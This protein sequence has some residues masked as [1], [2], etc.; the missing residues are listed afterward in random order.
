[1]N[2]RCDKSLQNNSKEFLKKKGYANSL[3]AYKLRKNCAN[4]KEIFSLQ[5]IKFYTWNKSI[6]NVSF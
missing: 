2:T 6:E 1:M 3:K 4:D 5:L